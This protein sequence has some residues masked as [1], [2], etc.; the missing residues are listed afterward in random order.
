MTTINTVIID[1]EEA[2][3]KVLTTLLTKFFPEVKICGEA[4]NM[5][6][7]FELIQDLK[8]DL[9]F[10]DVQMPGGNGFRLLQMFDSVFFKVIFVTG[11]DEFAI[12]AIKFNAL[13]YLLKPV[14]VADLENAVK[15][16]ME[17]KLM[18]QGKDLRYLGLLQ[19]ISTE[20]NDRKIIVHQ[21][22]KVLLLDASE[23][24]FMEADGRYSNIHTS[25]RKIFM[26]A[27]TLKDFEQYLIG[28]QSFFRINKEVLLN[29]KFVSNYTKGE[30]CFIETKTGEQF[31]LSRRKK[32][33]FLEKIKE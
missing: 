15:K 21:N 32:Q 12:Q 6:T 10:L 27:K 24:V 23:I 8:P 22:D 1:D 11:Y 30:P 31:E 3:R 7:G 29:I 26:V 33:E 9:V 14:E 19:S 17:S 2:S 5:T 18:E 13:D 25:E 4:G 28:N 20:S 16:A